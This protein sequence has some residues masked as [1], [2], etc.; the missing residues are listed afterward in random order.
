MFPVQDHQMAYQQ[1][2]RDPAWS[3]LELAMAAT[4]R[5]KIPAI[6]LDQSESLAD[7]HA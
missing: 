3:V 6:L 7:L 4:R 2:L 1:L 5:D